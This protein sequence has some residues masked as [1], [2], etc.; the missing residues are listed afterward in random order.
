[1]VF[2]EYD[3][4]LKLDYFIF[5]GAMLTL[6]IVQTSIRFCLNDWARMGG[7]EVKGQNFG[8][9]AATKNNHAWNR[10]GF[11]A[12]PPT[13]FLPSIPSTLYYYYYY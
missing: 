6:C 1:M 4:V 7:M 9:V 10:I 8:R 5:G 11:L 2:A 13:A 12:A 3:I